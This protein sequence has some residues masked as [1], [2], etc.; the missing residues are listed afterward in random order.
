MERISG[1]TVSWRPEVTGECAVLRPR[2]VLDAETSR[3]FGADLVRFAVE[4]PRALIVALD[5]LECTD[6]GALTV[7]SVVR[8]RV[9]DWPGVPILLVAAA[10]PL[11]RRV[12]AAVRRVPVLE[13]EAAALA[14]APPVPRGHRARLDMAAAAASAQCAREFVARMCVRWRTAEIFTDA[15]LL[16]TELVENAVRH[17]AGDV[18]VRLELRADGLTV[19]VADADP[20]PAVL[21]EPAAGEVQAYGLHVV[22]DLARAWGCAPRWPSG[23]VVWATLPV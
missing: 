11:R 19:A 2:G 13:S 18:G 3:R 16:V 20:H 12:A 10:E 4:Q 8:F 21:R 15:Q 14:A 23:K 9:G 5:E 6:D 7:F 17:G 22:A 1:G